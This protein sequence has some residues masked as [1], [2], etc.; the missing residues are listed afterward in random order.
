MG[1]SIVSN[2]VLLQSVVEYN[3]HTCRYTSIPPTTSPALVCVRTVWVYDSRLWL[4]FLFLCGKPNAFP[5]GH[6]DKL[7]HCHIDV[8]PNGL[9]EVLLHSLHE[10][11]KSLDHGNNLEEGRGGNRMTEE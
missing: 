4:V 8:P 10:Q 9:R 5:N 7:L 6:L 1:R 3:M 11:S 2:T